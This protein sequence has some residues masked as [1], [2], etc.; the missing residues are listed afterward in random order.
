MQVQ[1]FT[2]TTELKEPRE[3]PIILSLNPDKDDSPGFDRPASGHC[4]LSEFRETAENPRP[5][6]GIETRIAAETLNILCAMHTGRA[7]TVLLYNKNLLLFQMVKQTDIVR[8][9]KKLCA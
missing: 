7:T 4:Q 1:T 6:F 3:S 9:D 5:V 2:V 8:G